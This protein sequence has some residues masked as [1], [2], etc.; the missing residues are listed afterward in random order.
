MCSTLRAAPHYQTPAHEHTHTHT[1]KHTHT[2]GIKHK[3]EAKDE[4]LDS[5]EHARVLSAQ[6]DYQVWDRCMS[7]RSLALSLSLA[8]SRS[9]SLSLALSRSRL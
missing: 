9:L 7:S 5:S 6:L 1:H 4:E 8:L 3:Q 2:Q